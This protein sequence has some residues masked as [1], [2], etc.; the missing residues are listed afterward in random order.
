MAVIEIQVISDIVC[1]VSGN[2]RKIVEY[3]LRLTSYLHFG[4]KVVLRCQTQPRPGHLSISEDLPWRQIR[5]LCHHLDAVLPELQ[6]ALMQ[7]RKAYAGRCSTTQHH[8]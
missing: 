6:P 8:S 7:C 1:A 3:E 5:H 2:T 4:L